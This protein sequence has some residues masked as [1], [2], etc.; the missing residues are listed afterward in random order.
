MWLKNKF[1]LN[2]VKPTLTCIGELTDY[3]RCNFCIGD[4][5]VNTILRGR[6]EFSCQRTKR[7]GYHHETTVWY[8]CLAEFQKVKPGSSLKPPKLKE[9][10]LMLPSS[11]RQ[12]I[13]LDT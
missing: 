12:K 10:Y 9:C 11:P 4:I 8:I 7:V 5:V 1:R 6:K 3:K 13:E 2:I